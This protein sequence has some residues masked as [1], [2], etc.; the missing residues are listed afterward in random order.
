MRLREIFRFELGYQLRRVPTWLY[1]AF[2]AFVAFVWT[3]EN[4]LAYARNGDF[5]FGAPFVVAEVTVVLCVFWMLVAAYVAGDAAARDV[6]TGMHPLTYTTPVRKAD[7]LGGRFLAAF[8]LN[9][10]ILLA[11]LAG[12]LLAVHAPGVEAEI[13]GPFRPAAY[14]TAY[15][16]IAL[17]NAFVA[18]AIQFSF[19]ALRRRAIASYLGGVLLL[20]TAFV[21]FLLLERDVG[22]LLDPLGLIAIDDLRSKWT[23]IELNT[24]LM[25]LEGWWLANRLLWLGIALGTLAVTH[26]RFRLSHHT[27]TP[28]WSRISRRRD[29]HSPTPAASGILGNTPVSVPQ[30]RRTFGFRAHARQT[31]A[32]AWKSFGNIA[33]SRGGLLLLAVVAIFALVSVDPGHMGV[34]LLP[35][36]DHVLH[37]LVDPGVP[38]A[39]LIIPL[40]I[41]FC[42]AELVWR[43]RE[44]SLS[45]IVDAAPVPEW[46]LFLGRFLGLGLVLALCMVLRMMAGVLHQVGRGYYD[47]EVGLYLQILF[48]LQ[49]AD[50]LLLALLALVVHVV[51]NQK[52]VGHLVVL[53][54]FVAI[55]AAYGNGIG[56][57][58]LVYG[59]DPGW[60]YTDMRGFGPSLGPW[61]WFNLYWTAWALLLALVA[62]LL[63]VRGNEEGLGVRLRVARRRF[64]RPTAWA[65]SAAVG[66]ILTSGGFIFYNTNVLNE[67]GTASDDMERRAEY[68]RRYGEYE[69]IPQPRLTG[70]N[71]HVEIHPER[72]AVDIRGTYR[73]VNGS[74]VP[75]D[76]VHLASEVDPGEVDF[77]RPATGVLVDEL[78]GHRI[79]ALKEPLQPGDSLRL[80]FEAH[81]EPR[82]FRYRGVD[83]S[84]V[85]NGTYFTNR[86]LP[87]IGYQPS[88]ELSSAGAR[89][90]HGLPPRPAIPSLDDAQARLDMTGTE[91]IAFEAVVSTDEGQI[92]VAP[93]ALIRT[94]TEGGRRYFHYSTDAPIG[95]EYAF[96]S[97]DYAVHEGRWND[98]AI[99]IFHHPGHTA[100]LE[101]MV[102]SVRASLGHYTER[103]GPYPYGHIRLVEHPGHGLG[104]HAEANTIDYEEGFSLLNP[105]DGPRGLDLPFYVVAHEVAHQW[106]GAQLI[107]ARVEG[108]GV[109]V[110]SLASY[111]AYQ[112]VEESYGPEH[113]RRLLGRLRMAYQVPRTHAAVP[114]LRAND[115]FLYYRKGPFALYALS[116][117]IGAERVNDALRRLLEEHGSGAPPLPTSLDLYRELQAVTPDSLQHL[118]HD[119]FEAN[120]FWELG[121]EQATAEQTE[122]GTWQ[123]ILD[124]RARKVVVDTAG[125][126]T[127]VP[128]DDW[129]EVGVFAPVEESEQS[130]EPLYMRMHRVRSTEQTITVT[131]PRKPAHAGIDPYHLLIDLEMGDN[132]EEVK[133]E[134]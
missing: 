31:L 68:E 51:V 52:H 56:H 63:W 59:S 105:G 47:L 90:L 88:R 30:V 3:G 129:V 50:Y 8:V 123:V 1:V 95:N 121:I 64:T 53:L 41:V 76:S 86:W 89:R 32:I 27:A 58:L 126:E 83:N 6:E 19:A 23:P 2:L 71:L 70:T 72:R 108:A 133:I 48:G 21:L 15:A 9:A 77:D 29:A 110:E 40:L 54:I 114:L 94:W 22:Q 107:P 103:F 24:R 132:I 109:L 20:V 7:Y 102:R 122:A 131:V 14:L 18:T 75:I 130:G 84:V 113:L 33:K 69:G 73:L 101:R 134:I 66:L 118:L 124:V 82:G 39:Y 78:L 57:H 61:L 91:R 116:Q 99:Q 65:A 55:I 125:V 38:P 111:S 16:F 26:F 100:N 112:V 37:G 128:M 85:A 92:A 104:M 115:A 74:A 12:I 120:T 106:W 87:A 10:L 28:C 36:A 34:P 11:V 25:A 49:L 127:E 42:S 17:P 80:D 5:F 93:G 60:S 79:Y 46:V 97:A 96:F 43:E 98:V 44:A 81:I 4:Y 117:Y 62:R 119:L 45:E 67:Y 35:R 13:R